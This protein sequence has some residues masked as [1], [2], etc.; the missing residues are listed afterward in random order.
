MSLY[1]ALQKAHTE[2]DFKDAYIKALGRKGHTEV[3]I[4]IQSKE[5][6]STP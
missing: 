2:E 3:L 1:A 4:D 5:I 6:V